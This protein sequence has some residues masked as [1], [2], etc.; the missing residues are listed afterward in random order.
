MKENFTASPAARRRTRLSDVAKDA[1]VSPATVSR[2]L[3]RPDLLSEETLSRVRR[4]AERLGYKPD[5]AARALAS[6]RSMTIGA[7]V[8]TL[9]NAIFSKALQGMQAALAAEGYQLLVASHDFNPAAETEAI[10]NLLSRGVDG[11]ILV[12][13]ERAPEAA[14][15]LAASPV[16]VVLTWRAP[17]GVPAIVVDNERAGEIAARHLIELGHRRIGAITGA[18]R[19]NDRQRA[20]RDGVRLALEQAGLTLPAS[21]VCEQSPTLAGGR[22][23]C[24]KL[25]ELADPPTAIVCGIDLIAIGCM[26]E[27]QARGLSVPGDLSIAGIDDLDMSAHV[28][29]SLTTVHVP[30]AQIGSEAAKKLIAVLRQQITEPWACLPVELIVRRSTGPAQP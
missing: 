6:G 15:L 1:G 26:V 4:A 21:L 25:L 20:R 29:P 28:S 5:A 7:V 3:S 27:A 18:V 9:D 19:F 14:A 23:G 24:T 13:A 22:M 17:P 11:L 8:P 12:G 10:R 16:P 2:A 30:T